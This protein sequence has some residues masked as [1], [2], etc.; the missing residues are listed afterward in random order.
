MTKTTCALI[1]TLGAAALL[2]AAGMSIPTG[3][4]HAAQK[5][6]PHISGAPSPGGNW[7]PGSTFTVGKKTYICD[8]DGNWIIIVDEIK[9]GTGDGT[10][11]GTPVGRPVVPQPRDAAPAPR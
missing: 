4:A 5:T 1:R 6:C 2:A 10:P 7:M 11:A 8:D 3:A 9:P